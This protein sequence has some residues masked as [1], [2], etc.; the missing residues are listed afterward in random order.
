[1]AE[2]IRC[3][4]CGKIIDEVEWAQKT[5]RKNETDDTWRALDI[6]DE[7][8]ESYEKRLKQETPYIDTD[9]LVRLKKELELKSKLADKRKEE[10]DKLK[11]RLNGIYGVHSDDKKGSAP[12]GIEEVIALLEL[13]REQADKY[14]FKKWEEP[15]CC[16]LKT[17]LYSHNTIIRDVELDSFIFVIDN[18]IHALRGENDET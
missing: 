16:V 13:L 4:R 8:H 14:D 6:C 18:A 1:M 9:I 5:F 7:C 17:D 3:D 10:I 11:R 12:G 15:P 2:V